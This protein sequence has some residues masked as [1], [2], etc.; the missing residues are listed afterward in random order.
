VQRVAHLFQG[1]DMNEII[2]DEDVQKALDYLRT[3]APKAAQA[4]ANKMYMEEYRKT[5]KA[6]MM[7]MYNSLPVNAQEREAYRSKTYTDHL[8]AMQEAVYQDELNRWGMVAA[9]STIEA[10]RTQN[11]N[12]RG[13]GKL[14]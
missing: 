8:K 6:Q 12:R 11:A 4:K 9:T 2:S 5:V 7:T 14:Q 1:D 3:N 10:W 13:E